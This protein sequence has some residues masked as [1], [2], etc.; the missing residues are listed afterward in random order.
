MAY[1]SQEHPCPGVPG[2][3]FSHSE[4]DIPR[5]IISRSFN[6]PAWL[7]KFRKHC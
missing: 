5:P 4:P 1:W 7:G 6:D 3:L 2:D